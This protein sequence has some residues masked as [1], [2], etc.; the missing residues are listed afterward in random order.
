M[1]SGWGGRHEDALTHQE[2]LVSAKCPLVGMGAMRMPHLLGDAG[3]NMVFSGGA[4]SS[5]DSMD[6]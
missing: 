3:Q 1:S 2:M 4:V 5:E 6:H